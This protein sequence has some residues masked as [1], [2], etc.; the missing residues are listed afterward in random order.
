MFP[1]RVFSEHMRGNVLGKWFLSSFTFI[2][3]LIVW[4]SV[5]ILQ[6]IVSCVC[7]GRHYEV[8]Y[9]IHEQYEEEVGSVNEEV[10]GDLAFF[11]LLF[12]LHFCRMQ[13]YE[14]F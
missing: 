9:L 1:Y 4:I 8:L 11:F 5:D 14:N 6:L 10:Q 13:V 2:I 7:T 3:E 12:C